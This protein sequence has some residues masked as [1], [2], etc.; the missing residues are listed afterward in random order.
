[1]GL[2]AFFKLNS[3]EARQMKS[4]AVEDGACCVMI[5]SSAAARKTRF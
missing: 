3:V 4:N 1:M 2:Q 5:H